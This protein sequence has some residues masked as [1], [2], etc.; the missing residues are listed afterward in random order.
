M[1]PFA[2]ECLATD[3]AERMLAHLP[4]RFIQREDGTITVFAVMVFVLMVGVGGIAIDLMRYETQRVQLQYTLDRAVLAAGSLNQTRSPEEVVRNY[5]EAAGLG[6][7][8]LRVDVEDGINSRTVRV[9]AE[10]EVHTLF[11]SLF[12]QRVLSS[13]ASGAAEERFRKVEVS[14]VLDVSGSMWGSRINA[15]RPAA[16][17]FVTTIL[18]ANNN[19]DGDQLVSVSLVPYNQVVNVGTTLGSVYQLSAEHN[20]SRCARFQ[21][22]DFT[23]TGLNPAVPIL[24]MAHLDW[25]TNNTVDPIASTVTCPRDNRQAIL[26]WSNN[27]AALHA[28]IN[29]FVAEGGTAIDAGVRWGV[30]LLDPMAR[31][32]LNGLTTTGVVHPDLE[33]R[34]AAYTDPDTMK[35]LVLMTDG[36]SSSQYDVRPHFR[37]GP[38]PFW[39]DPDNGRISVF[40]PQFNQFWQV[41][42]RV[43]RNVPDGGNNNNAIRLDYAHLWNHVPANS[44]RTRFFGDSAAWAWPNGGRRNAVQAAG[45]QH[46]FWNI[47]EEF[48]WTDEGDRRVRQLCNLAKANDQIRIFTIAFQAQPRGRQL[49]RDCASDDAHFYDAQGLNITDIFASIAGTIN[50]LRLI[51]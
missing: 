20:F 37:S 15:L 49:M 12:G 40:Y 11:M 14:L 8:R 13:P 36:E 33:N 35:I 47:V 32:A 31:P 2:A 46:S 23:Q 18:Q 7:Y 17:E 6:N 28:A 27:E 45:N 38:S 29:S 16:R 42:N 25:S 22:A 10:T 9:Q 1:R 30:A 48:V 39:R 3:A 5:F 51:E 34:P 19:P 4:R 41:N 43:W 21:A 44:V 26:P 24:R 50:Q